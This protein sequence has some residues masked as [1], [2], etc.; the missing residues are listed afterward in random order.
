MG[1]PGAGWKQMQNNQHGMKTTKGKGKTKE[2]IIKEF[3]QS[4]VKILKLAE[5]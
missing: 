1:V 5:K 3:D 2:H 4:L